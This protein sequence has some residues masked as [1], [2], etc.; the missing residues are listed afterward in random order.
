MATPWTQWR[1]DVFGDPYTVWHEG[2]EFT[3]LVDLARSQPDE[4]AHKLAEGLTEEDPVA[5]QAIAALAELDLAPPPAE[6]QLKAAATTATETFLIRVAQTLHTLTNDESWAVP[7]TSV[8]TS[9]AFWGVR[10]DAALAL[11]A[12]TPTQALIEALTK[13]TA[14]DE[15]LVRYHS[16]NTLLTYAGEPKSIGDQGKLFDQITRPQEGDPTTADRAEWQKTATKL[17]N[18]ALRRL[19]Q[20]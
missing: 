5:A 19:A 17:K 16:A 6:A 14:D 9:D 7:I 4:V 8:L 10:V 2:P 18:N 11:S 20:Q 15:Y 3:R 12:F 13:T 1:D